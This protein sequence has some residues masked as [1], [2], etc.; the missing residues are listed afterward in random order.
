MPDTI[1]VRSVYPFSDDDRDWLAAL[2]PR[3]EFVFAGR[4][5]AAWSAELDDPDVEVLWSNH[6]PP[7]LDGLPR[8]RWLAMASAGVDTVAALDPWGLGLTVTNG[9]GLHVVPMAEYVMAAALFATERVG[10]RLERQAAHAWR[11]ARRA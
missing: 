6:P 3:V 2:D 1:R 9:S 10:V 7:N 8:L 11:H 4:D 5:D